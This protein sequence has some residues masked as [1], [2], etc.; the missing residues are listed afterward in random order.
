MHVRERGGPGVALGGRAHW[1]WRP[2]H[3]PGP[4]RPNCLDEESDL[5]VGRGADLLPDARVR[6]TCLHDAICAPR[7]THGAM[8]EPSRGSR[9]RLR[10]PSASGATPQTERQVIQQREKRKQ[11]KRHEQVQ[12]RAADPQT[13]MSILMLDVLYIR[14][15]TLSIVTCQMSMVN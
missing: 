10:P 9:C 7:Q 15:C 13:L 12:Q 4:L 3:S 5:G 2:S 8:S 11:P 1:G 14:S 6:P